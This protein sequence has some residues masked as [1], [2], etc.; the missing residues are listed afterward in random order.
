MLLA[1]TGFVLF[2]I[3]AIISFLRGDVVAGLAF[4]GAAAVALHLAHPV[5]IPGRP[6]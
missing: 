1:L 5:G 2:L 3:A 4:T 6:A